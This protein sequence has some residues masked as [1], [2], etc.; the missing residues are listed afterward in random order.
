MYNCK[1]SQ[2]PR[3]AN[4][5]QIQSTPVF[6]SSLK[7]PVQWY[8]VN[9]NQSS[10]SRF[11]H[12]FEETEGKWIYICY[13]IIY[14]LTYFGSWERQHMAVEMVQVVPWF[15]KEKQESNLN[16]T[17]LRRF[18]FVLQNKLCVDTDLWKIYTNTCMELIKGLE[19]QHF[20]VAEIIIDAVII[21]FSF[22]ESEWLQL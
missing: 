10:C 2:R 16:S 17:W 4:P 14:T 3:Y 5:S 22:S 18:I 13:I 6:P 12:V 8:Y 7:Q 15:L 1:C 20:L 11:Y 9:W 21:I 19:E